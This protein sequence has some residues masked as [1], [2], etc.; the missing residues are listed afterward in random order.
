MRRSQ[1][2]G[3]VQERVTGQGEGGDQ[4]ARRL[5]QGARRRLQGARGLLLPHQGLGV[6]VVVVGE[7]GGHT[8][9]HVG[10]DPGHRGHRHRLHR[11]YVVI[12]LNM[13]KI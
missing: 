1:G 2:L 8:G 11:D 5:L 4:G 10:G 3:L 9:H 7:G 13:G 12:I 6:V